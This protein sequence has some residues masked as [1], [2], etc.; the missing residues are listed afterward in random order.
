[1][2]FDIFLYNNDIL[3]CII[4]NQILSQRTHQAGAPGAPGVLGVPG[5]LDRIVHTARR[6][7]ADPTAPT[8]RDHFAQVDPDPA[9]PADPARLPHSVRVTRAASAARVT[10]YMLKQPEVQLVLSPTLY[11]LLLL[12]SAQTTC[13][14]IYLIL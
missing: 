13:F 9:D 1:M 8:A 4:K 5:A 11:L 3:A 6:E 12:A 7:R 2:S 10:T 14:M